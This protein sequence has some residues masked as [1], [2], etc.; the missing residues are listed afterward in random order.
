[1]HAGP[2]LKDEMLELLRGVSLLR[3]SYVRVCDSQFHSQKTFLFV[4]YGKQEKKTNKN[5]LS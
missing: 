4:C 1:M 2:T 5:T 3:T